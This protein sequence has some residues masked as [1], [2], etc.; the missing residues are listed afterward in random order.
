VPL[1]LGDEAPAF[2]LRNQHGAMVSLADFRGRKNVVVMFYPWA[3]SG[4]CTRELL[5]VRDSLGD[6]NTATSELVAI[7]CDAMFSLRVL[8]DRDNLTF[9]LLSDF[10]P[11]GEVASRYGIFNER[12]GISGRAS[13]IV[14]REGVIRWQVGNAIGDARDLRAYRKVLADLA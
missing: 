10:W 12:L 8:A 4:V 7:S 1:N 5:E 13:F 2:S 3:F 11:H 9:T 6:V 14:D